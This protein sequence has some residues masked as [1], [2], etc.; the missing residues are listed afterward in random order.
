MRQYQVG[1]VVML[2]GY[3]GLF[4]F[5]FN[6]SVKLFIDRWVKP[7]LII[8]NESTIRRPLW[9]S[10]C[11]DWLFAVSVELCGGSSILTLFLGGVVFLFPGSSDY[12]KDLL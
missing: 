4:L 9:L 11:R 7:Y 6:D 2:L 1:I 12:C 10:A 5:L 3:E 8:I